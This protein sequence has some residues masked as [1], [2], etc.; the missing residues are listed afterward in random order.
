MGVP[1]VPLRIPTH[2]QKVCNLYKRALRCLESN[3]PDRPLLR[4]K[5]VLMRERFEKNRNEKDPIRATQYLIDGEKELFKK[6][7]FQPAVFAASAGELLWNRYAHISD[8]VLDYWHP[9][10]KAQY[11]EYFARRE[12]RKRQ[13]EQ[14]W[15][16]TYGK[17]GQNNEHH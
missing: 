16:K 10:E 9:L 1:N 17:P 14:W 15:E 6:A 13:M 4:Y 12:Q 5:S 3:E 7:H 11:P 8:S 2:A